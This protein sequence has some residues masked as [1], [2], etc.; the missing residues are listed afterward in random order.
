MNQPIRAPP[1]CSNC[2]RTSCDNLNIS[3]LLSTALAM[4]AS[5]VEWSQVRLPNKGSRSSSTSKK[6][7]VV[8][9]GFSQI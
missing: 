1:Q 6:L 7:F 2:R 9:T 8:V 4:T 3:Q 5:L